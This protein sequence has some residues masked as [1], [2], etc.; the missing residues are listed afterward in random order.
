MHKARKP[1]K[2]STTWL[3]FRRNHLDVSWAIDFF[4]VTSISFATLYFFLVFDHGRCKVI[5]F[6]IMRNPF[7]NRVIQQLRQ[8]LDVATRNSQSASK[9]LRLEFIIYLF[10]VVPERLHEPQPRNIGG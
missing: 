3:P 10:Q 7:M 6:A 4:T 8:G 5:H 9:K 1:R 2:R